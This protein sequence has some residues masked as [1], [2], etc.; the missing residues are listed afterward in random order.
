[1]LTLFLFYEQMKWKLSQ[2]AGNTADIVIE[3][4][5]RGISLEPNTPIKPNRRWRWMGEPGQVLEDRL[6]VKT[7]KI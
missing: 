6:P 2:D 7:K 5:K 1:M 4:A 3:L